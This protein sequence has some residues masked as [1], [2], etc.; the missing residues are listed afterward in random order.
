MTDESLIALLL[1][2]DLDCLTTELGLDRGECLS[3][4]IYSFN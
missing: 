1:A 4:Q 2:S 3:T